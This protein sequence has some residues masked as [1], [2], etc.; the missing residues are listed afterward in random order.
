VNWSLILIKNFS[1][2]DNKLALQLLN[3]LQYNFPIVHQPFSYISEN[4]FGEF[5]ESDVIELLSNSMNCGVLS[6]VGAIFP[7]NSVGNS[8]LAAMAVPDNM[9]DS[10]VELINSYR[11][12]NHNYLRDHFYNLWFV[13]AANNFELVESTLERIYLASGIKPLNL[14]L[15]KEYHIDLAFDFMGGKSASI[16]PSHSAD[17]DLAEPFINYFQRDKLIAL[18]SSGIPFVPRPFHEIG[19]KC[20]LKENDVI[21][22]ILF[23]RNVGIIKRF[24][25]V[26][27]HYELGFRSNAMCVWKINDPNERNKIALNLSAEPA[28][29]LCYERPARLP[30]WPYQLFTM[31]HARDDNELMGILDDIIKRNS[32]YDIQHE[33]LRSTKRFK[34]S[35]AQYGSN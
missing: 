28:I 17:T 15:V 19:L 8:T 14:P 29:T 6:R 23:W 10:V 25:A 27:R 13:V 9:L 1:V 22:Q 35:G 26:V 12:V 18:L 4:L 20:G 30:E 2:L 21:N 16:L 7:P 24:G 3:D 11:E 34:Q 31:I 32:L 5:T 33:I